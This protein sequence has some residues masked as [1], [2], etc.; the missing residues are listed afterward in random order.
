MGKGHVSIE[1]GTFNGKKVYIC[2]FRNLIGKNLYNGTISHKF[3]KKR[4]IE[5]KAMKLQLKVALVTTDVQTKK[6]SVDYLV[7]TFSRSDD[8]S[9]FEKEFDKAI[10]TLKEQ[11]EP[12]KG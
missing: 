2:V 6:A 5:E 4:R 8:L 12:V 11:A 7:I 1:E 10:E 3:S 9:L